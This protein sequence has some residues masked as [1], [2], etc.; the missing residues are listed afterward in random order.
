MTIIF[1][2][3]NRRGERLRT[4]KI[5]DEPLVLDNR[6]AMLGCER[7]G[8]PDTVV[9]RLPNVANPRRLDVAVHDVVKEY[10]SSHSPVAPV[11]EGR[12]VATDAPAT[13]LSQ[14]AGTNYRFR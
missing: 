11:I 7:E 2:S 13:L 3:R 8:D 1:T 14:L 6:Y 4:V 5:K 9:C 10:L 12:A